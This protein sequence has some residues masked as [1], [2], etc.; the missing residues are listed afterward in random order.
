MQ[1]KCEEPTGTG[2]FRTT[3]VVTGRFVE[4]SRNEA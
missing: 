1:G 4:M 2:P 3:K